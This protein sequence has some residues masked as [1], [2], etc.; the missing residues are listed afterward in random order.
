RRDLLVDGLRE[1]GFQVIVPNG[2]YFVCADASPLLGSG[3]QPV[4]VGAGAAFARALPELVGV[5]AVP[6]SAFCREGSATARALD[7]W[8]RFT[9]VKDEQTLRTAVERLRALDGAKEAA[10]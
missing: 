5:A 1:A 6:I 10:V 4:D 7:P 8:L 3:E 9:F 2:T